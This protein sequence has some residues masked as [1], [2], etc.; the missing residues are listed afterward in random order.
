MRLFSW[1]LKLPQLVS[2]LAFS[3]LGCGTT[4]YKHQIEITID[5]PLR[6]LGAPPF[7]V[8]IFDH[9]QGYERS[10]ALKAV[11]PAARGKPYRAPYSSQ[12][13]GS[14]FGGPPSQLVIS[15]AI[16]KLDDSGYFITELAP[17]SGA[18]QRTVARFASYGSFFPD[19]GGATLPVEYVARSM[20]QGWNIQLYI[21]V[22]SR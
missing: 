2:I 9:Y 5:D 8:S 7:D 21:T 6:R 19:K 10:W 16:P 13:T 4:V 18:K 11:G 17:R 14:F 12:A 20:D 1:I 22:S 15:I 3:L